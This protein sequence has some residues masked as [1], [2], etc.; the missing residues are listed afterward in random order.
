MQQMTTCRVTMTTPDRMINQAAETIKK[1]GL[2]AMPT[3]TVYGLAADATND[4]AVARIFEAK[5]RPTFNPLI[6]HVPDLAAAEEHA[7]ISPLAR[8]LAES[9]WPGPLTLVTA[10]RPTSPLSLLLSAGLD[11]IALRAPAHPIARVLLEAAGTP[12]AAPSANRSGAVSPT[13]ATHVRESLGD[14]VDYVLDGGASNVGVES[15]IVHVNGGDAFLLR[16]G[17]VDRKTIERIIGA[18]LR[19]HFD[20]EQ[21]LAPGML[22]SHYAPGAFLRLDAQSAEPDEAFLGFGDIAGDTAHSLNLSA[23][24]DLREAAANLFAHLRALDAVCFKNSLKKIAV[25]PIPA[26]GLGEAINDR[27]TR[28]AAPREKFE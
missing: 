2:V 18:P 21:P 1:G 19:D 24:G 14:K 27:L 3:E 26:H 12:V 11:T 23:S 9:L 22:A 16:A 10:R 28:A 7:T 17:G 5:G 15:T 4:A 20:T 6:A 25:A 8:I 13:T